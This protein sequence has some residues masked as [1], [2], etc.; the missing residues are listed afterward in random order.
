MP[1]DNTTEVERH[2]ALAKSDPTVFSAYGAT[3]SQKNYSR[4]FITALPGIAR[5]DSSQAGLSSTG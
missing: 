1:K 5:K 4:N 2:I 3:V